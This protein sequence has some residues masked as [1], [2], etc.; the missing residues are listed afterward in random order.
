[1][2]SKLCSVVLPNPM[3]GSRMIFCASIPASAARLRL[4]AKK[5]VIHSMFIKIE[6]EHFF[7][8]YNLQYTL[9]AVNR[10]SLHL[11]KNEKN[12]V[13]TLIYR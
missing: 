10:F 6:T 13:K 12:T 9:A 1:M 2:V 5:V 11:R 8:Y 4:F 3:P 7:F